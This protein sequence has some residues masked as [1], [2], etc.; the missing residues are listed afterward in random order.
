MYNG[1]SEKY[2]NIGFEQTVKA[3]RLLQ[4]VACSSQIEKR[5]YDTTDTA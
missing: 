5:A 1:D 2:K 4:L 3:A